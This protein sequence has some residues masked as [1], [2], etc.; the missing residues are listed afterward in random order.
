MRCKKLV[1]EVLDIIW[2][3]KHHVAKLF[4]NF[5]YLVCTSQQCFSP[6]IFFLIPSLCFCSKI[7]KYINFCHVKDKT[8][9]IHYSYGKRLLVNTKV[10]DLTHYF[11]KDQHLELQDQITLQAY[12]KFQAV[13]VYS[14][15]DRASRKLVTS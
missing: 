3:F 8:I 10:S 5:A 9:F 11:Q 7:F 15:C 14:F 2:E 6:Y 4:T 1:K 12:T 13:L